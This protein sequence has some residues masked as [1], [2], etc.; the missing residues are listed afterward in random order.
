MTKRVHC[1]WLGTVLCRTAQVL[2]MYRCHEGMRGGESA[3]HVE[4]YGRC[5]APWPLRAC[6]R[7]LCCWQSLNGNCNGTPIVLPVGQ[8][9]LSRELVRAQQST[10]QLACRSCTFPRIA[11]DTK[12]CAAC[13]WDL[14]A[15][16]CYRLAST[17]CTAAHIII[18]MYTT[19]VKESLAEVTA[20]STDSLRG[21]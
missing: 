10:Q 9:G 4:I 21:T 3:P 8:V 17:I 20:K 1:C 7:P 14:G 11:S 18:M 2:D 6:Q 15:Q 12:P 16:R 19:S 13:Q 5:K